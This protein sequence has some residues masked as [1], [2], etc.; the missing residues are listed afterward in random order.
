MPELAKRRRKKLQAVIDRDYEYQSYRDKDVEVRNGGP[1]GRGLYA[2]RQFLPGELVVE[3]GG[4]L[5]RKKDYPTS[6]YVMELDDKWYLEPDIPAAFSNHSCNPNSELVQLT[7]HTLGIVAVCNIEPETEIRYDY[8]WE[9]GWWVPEC[10]CGA[11]NCRG[12]VVAEKEIEKMRRIAKRLK[13]KNK[14]KPR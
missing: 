13:R 3:V 11:P 1:C 5:H 4:Q 10:R 2:V 7:K 8:Q 9:A 12:W 6:L 14:K